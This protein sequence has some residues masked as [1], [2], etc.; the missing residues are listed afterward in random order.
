[1]TLL[2]ILPWLQRAQREGFAVGAYNANNLEQIQAIV[3]AAE[4]ELAP[5]MI[6]ISHRALKYFGTGDDLLGLRYVVSAVQ[7]AAGTVAAPISLHLDHAPEAVVRRAI[8]AGF[9]SVMFDGGDLPFH[10]NLARTQVLCE[11][12]HRHGICMEA[13]VGEVPRADLQGQFA[14]A[15]DLTDPDQAAEFVTAAGIDVLAIAIGSVHA[16]REKSVQLDIERLKAIHARVNTP[17]VLHGSSGVTDASISE[18]I[19]LGLCKV[20]IATQLNQAF[21]NAIRQVLTAS[22]GEIDPR[23]YLGPARDTMT[24]AIQERMR[25]LGASG[26]A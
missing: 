12:A 1:M 3:A 17:L 14:P 4:A 23:R 11:I 26:K 25:F 8:E 13:E 22:S 15:D 18:G 16:V 10:E 21:T 9:T 5:A 2:N 19:K 20:N 7:I 24:A 6:Q